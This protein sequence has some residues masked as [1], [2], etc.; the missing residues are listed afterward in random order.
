MMMM[1]MRVNWKCTWTLL[2]L[3]LSLGAG[4]SQAASAK[5]E[6]N[7]SLDPA[8]VFNRIMNTGTEKTTDAGRSLADEIALR[9]W[10]SRMSAPE[11]AD[12]AQ[13]QAAL[14]GLVHRIRSVKFEAKEQV[15]ATF[16]VPEPVVIRPDAAS[17]QGTA[18]Q[19][20]VQPPVTAPAAPD[21]TLPAEA[22]E[23]LKRVLAD[24]NQASEPLELAELL[25]LTGRLNEAAI[26]YQKA[27][28]STGGNEPA[29]REDRAWIL[30]QLGNCLRETN[31]ARA[32]DMYTKLVAEHADSPWVELAKAH[33]QLISWYEQVQ[34]RQ[35]L[36]GPEMPPT[37]Q[38]AASQKPQP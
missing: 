38:V 18:E 32:R 27:L 15:A 24:P 23:A 14:N 33:S 9:L 25:Y 29:S 17:D 22:V 3:V 28:D 10:R 8:S 21:G 7:D 6:P 2:M 30:L 26:L 19:R 35:W 1:M 13:I 11:Q 16:T 34:P 36:A 12:D 4:A 20:I 31:P 5:A 37:R